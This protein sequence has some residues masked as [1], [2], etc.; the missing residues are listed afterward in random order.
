MCIESIKWSSWNQSFCIGNTRK[1]LF[2]N[3]HTLKNEE[4][5]LWCGVC[6]RMCVCVS[7]WKTRE[8]LKIDGKCL[9]GEATYEYERRRMDCWWM[10]GWSDRQWSVLMMKKFLLWL[11]TYC[12]RN[13]YMQCAVFRRKISRVYMCVCVWHKM[14]VWWLNRQKKIKRK[15]TRKRWPIGYFQVINV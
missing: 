14:F 5:T 2:K 9:T 3:R 15:T 1:C 12:Y 6:V 4:D 13:L 8:W 11:Y 10:V 7:Q